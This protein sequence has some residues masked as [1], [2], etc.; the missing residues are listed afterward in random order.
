M[1]HLKAALWYIAGFVL[2][3]ISLSQTAQNSHKLRWLDSIYGNKIDGIDG[4]S[5]YKAKVSTLRRFRWTQLRNPINNLLR[6]YGAN[7]TVMNVDITST[8][9]RKV[10][11]ALI[12]GEYYKFS[13]TLL[14]GQWHWW[15]GVKLLNDDRIGSKLEQGHHFENMMIIW[16][17]KNKRV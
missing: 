11:R 10:I 2:V 7:G 12:S 3:P 13:Q 15:W 16:P 14:F 1:K 4:D 9:R 8:P 17:I 5:A 6:A